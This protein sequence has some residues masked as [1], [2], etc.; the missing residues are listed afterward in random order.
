M[1][2]ASRFTFSVTN[3][4][5]KAN[6]ADAHALEAN[7]R[8]LGGAPALDGA[9]PD[10][11]LL[12][13]CTVT[14]NAD[15]EAAQILRKT[16]AGFTVATGCFAEVD[17]NGLLAAG[18]KAGA[19]FRVLRNAAKPELSQMVEQWLAN[20]LDEQKKIWNG[21]RAAWHSSFLQNRSAEELAE[22][23]GAP[24]TRVFLKV[25]DGCNA[26]CSYCV[27]PLARGRSRS[28]PPEQVV[29]EVNELVAAGV[30]E[31][32]LTAIHAADFEGEGG[33]TGLVKKVLAE[34]RVPR[35]R[36]TSLDPAEIP[37]ELLDLMVA[38]PRLCPH[39]HVSLQCANDRVL[40]A[41]KRGYGAREIEERLTMIAG[42]LPH[43]FVGM[44]VI[45]G[46]P[47]ETD[48]EFEDT[49][50]RLERLPWT[51]AHVFPFSVRRQTAAAR[52]ADAGLCVPQHKISDRARRLRELSSRKLAASLEARIG[53]VAEILVEGKELEFQGRKVS[54]GHTRS[55]FKVIIPGRHP[56]NE[57]KR[58]R[59]VG[60]IGEDALKGELV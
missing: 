11:H 2:N 51:R 60:R 55:Y 53:S 15:R 24:R 40:T 37:D 54:A 42:R 6:L 21:D 29:R 59:I 46:F 9:A 26:F 27:I 48:E 49:F 7:L 50:A 34:T 41:M 45:A 36:L 23:S 18:E 16:G 28:L 5:C 17:P 20:T 52:L 8:A 44:D 39:F 47:G 1:L 13:T 3:M 14:D 30:K 38:E 22:P 58:V 35:L 4:G 19:N 12:N 57:L 56:A 10:L 33:F 25:Q 32:V 43:A 31:V